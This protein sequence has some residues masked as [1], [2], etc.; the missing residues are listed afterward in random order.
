MKRTKSM[1]LKTDFTIDD[2]EI[3]LYAANNGRREL[4]NQYNSIC[5]NLAKKLKK[6][7]FDVNKSIDLW[8]CL[9]NNAARFY[10]VDFGYM[11]PVSVRFAAA[12]ILAIEWAAD[13]TPFDF[14]EILQVLVEGV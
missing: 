4:Q 12:E 2:R 6:G 3:A 11:A 7:V 1:I 8:Y 9:T 10:N 14:K 5:D 13:K